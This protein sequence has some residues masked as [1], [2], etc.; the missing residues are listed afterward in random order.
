MICTIDAAAIR[1]R[2]GFHDALSAALS[3]PDWYGRNLDALYD[4]LTDMPETEIHVLHGSA[5]REN[6][7]EYGDACLD[8]FRDAARDNPNLRLMLDGGNDTP[9]SGPEL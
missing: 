7:G 1:D 2:E 4:C 8:T 5:L 3:L 9:D 6:L